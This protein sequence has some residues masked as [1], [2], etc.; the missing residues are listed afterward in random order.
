MPVNTIQGCHK[1]PYLLMDGG[2]VPLEVGG[3]RTL[4]IALVAGE[5]AIKSGI[6]IW[7]LARDLSAF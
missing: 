1:P 4:V 2:D 6:Q 5:A 3:Q 7:Y